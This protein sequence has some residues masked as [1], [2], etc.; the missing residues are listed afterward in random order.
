M[1]LSRARRF[2]GRGQPA[3]WNVSDTRR[4]ATMARTHVQQLSRAAFDRIVRRPGRASATLRLA[5]LALAFD[6]G[7][8]STAAASPGAHD[9]TGDAVRDDFASWAQ[10]RATAS[11][12]SVAALTEVELDGRPGIELVARLCSEDGWLETLLVQGEAGRWLVPHTSWGHTRVCAK[13]SADVPAWNAGQSRLVLADTG[14]GA[15]AERQLAIVDA[16]VV[17]ISEWRAE[18]GVTSEARWDLASQKTGRWRGRVVPVRHA[19]DA[20]PERGPSFVTDGAEHWT[21]SADADLRA[22]AERREDGTLLLRIGFHD[23]T[24]EHG[25]SGDR[26]AVWWI[27]PGTGTKRGLDIRTNDDG[28]L[29]TVALQSKSAPPAVHGSLQQLEVVLPWTMSGIQHTTSTPLSIVAH[30]VDGATSTTIA[31]SEFD[32]RRESMGQLRY[33]PGGGDY[34]VAGRIV[35]VPSPYAALPSPPLARR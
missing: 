19:N 16:Q 33:V 28:T 20:A 4:K 22:V 11:S 32:G 31:T 25:L 8:S 27:D 34:E 21:G 5:L 12:S 29:R 6:G 17:V 2:F 26:L 18:P 23:D 1:N 35:A 30:D 14:P 10:V 13:P 7:A 24:I 15:Q 9:T 3:C